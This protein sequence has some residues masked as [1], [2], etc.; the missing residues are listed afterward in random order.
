[1]PFQSKSFA[2]DF[3]RD[4]RGA[5]AV[6]FGLMAMVLLILSGIAVD[7]ARLYQSNSK[8]MAAADAAALAAGRALLDGQ[9]SDA[10][11][12]ELGEKFFFENI[13]TGGNLAEV[14][15]VRVTPNRAEN[16]VRI[17]VDADVPMTLTRVAGFQTVAT[18]VKSITNFDRRDIELSLALDVTGSMSGAKL[19]DLK[20]AAS[21][22][23]DILLPDNSYSNSVRIGLAPYAASINAGSYARMV[24]NNA[25]DRCVHERSGVQAFTDAAPGFGTWIGTSAGLSCPSAQIE[26][27]SD[28]K[29][30]LKSRIDGYS[31]GGMTAG[32][33]GAAWAW[34]LVSPEWAS[35]WPTESRPVAYAEDNT[36]KAIVLMTDGVFNTH[37]ISANGNST[38]QALNVCD[39]MKSKGVIVYSVA[40]Q[41]PSLAETLLR[42]CATSGD[43]YFNASSGEELRTAFKAVAADL[44]N[45]RLTQ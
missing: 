24:T 17:D 13:K 10:E 16:S 21:D 19:E 29:E 11:V 30:L 9:L 3:A 26:P 38:A 33:L 28:N 41:A 12:E 1:M 8:L 44:N 6:L 32:H 7:Q 35:I 14:N 15:S 34:Y 2:V 23:I 43:T 25:S 20:A 5:V 45:L 4:E 42:D 39:E 22:L 37:Y 27:L 31:A 18:P 40:F 36:V